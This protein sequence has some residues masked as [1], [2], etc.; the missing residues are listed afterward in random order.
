MVCGWRSSDAPAFP[1]GRGGGAS[2]F[3]V[4]DRDSRFN[5]TS[6]GPQEAAVEIRHYLKG[7][8]LHI[9]QKV[10]YHY[11]RKGLVSDPLT[12]QDKT[13]LENLNKVWHDRATI[14]CMMA[15]LNESERAWLPHTWM[16][17]HAERWALTRFYNTQGEKKYPP[18]IKTVMEE[19]ARHKLA[20]LTEERLRELQK[21]ARYLRKKEKRKQVA[22]QGIELAKDDV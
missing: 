1:E 7:N 17:T 13:F 4:T 2:R 8:R 9:P 10:V 14:G 20:P 21:T 5:G 22:K 11:K 6:R 16:L 18:R 19:M 3:N 12:A 15:K